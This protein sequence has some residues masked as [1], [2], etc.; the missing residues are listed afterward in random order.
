MSS[1]VSPKRWPHVARLVALLGVT[2]RFAVALL[3]ATRLA[4][5]AASAASAAVRARRW[6]SST[7]PGGD[8]TDAQRAQV[9]DTLKAN[10]AT[11]VR[12]DVSWRQLE[13]TTPACSTPGARNNVNNAI[14]MAATRGLK[15]W[16]PSG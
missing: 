12:I 16:S 3:A 14:T 6:G 2:A 4:P 8:Y 15:P 1:T 9:L 7:A 13:P 5:A 10:G 11:T